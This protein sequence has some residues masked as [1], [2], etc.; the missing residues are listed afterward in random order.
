[1]LGMETLRKLRKREK[2]QTTKEC[3]FCYQSI[4]LKASR[5]QFCTAVL[6]ENTGKVE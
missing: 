6:N 3:P 4:H 1:M 5:C 2:E